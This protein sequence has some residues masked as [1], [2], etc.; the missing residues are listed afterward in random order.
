MQSIKISEYKIQNKKSA[1]LYNLSKHLYKRQLHTVI[2]LPQ[3]TAHSYAFHFPVYFF[4]MELSWRIGNAEAGSKM[5]RKGRQDP[6]LPASY[7]VARRF[8]CHSA[9]ALGEL[10]LAEHAI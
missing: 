1:F 3:P 8:P 5:E 6:K 10:T 9:A 7:A 2:P 4:S